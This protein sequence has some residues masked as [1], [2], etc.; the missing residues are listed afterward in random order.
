LLALA[1]RS[2]GGVV[3]KYKWTVSNGEITEGQGT[4]EIKVDTLGYQG[5]PGQSD[6]HC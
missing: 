6:P 2:G 1:L 4:S 5:L 3:L